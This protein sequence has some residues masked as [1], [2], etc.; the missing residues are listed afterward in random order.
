MNIGKNVR[1]GDILM[2]DLGTSNIIGS[3][4]RGTR[5]AVVIQNNKG[6]F[7][8]TTII[9]ALVTTRNKRNY[10]PTHFNI[11][12]DGTESVV[13]CEQIRTIDKSRVVR[14]LGSINAEDV[15]KLNECLKVSQEL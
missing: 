10:I 12:I 2:V 15:E 7:F 11:D 3:E 6:N 13:M 8:S 1:R 9:I 5:P 14:Y 4:Q